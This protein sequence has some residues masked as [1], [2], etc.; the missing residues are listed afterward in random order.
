[1]MCAY[2]PGKGR[3]S[4]AGPPGLGAGRSR[5]ASTRCPRRREGRRAG[6]AAR[7]PLTTVIQL[8]TSGSGRLLRAS[9]IARAGTVAARSEPRLFS[10]AVPSA[11]HSERNAT[12]PPRSSTDTHGPLTCG[13]LI[14]EVFETDLGRVGDRGVKAGRWPRRRR[15]PRASCSSV[16]CVSRQRGSDQERGLHRLARVSRGCYA[17]FSSPCRS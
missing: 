8:P 5:T 6:A 1:V 9:S 17:Q 16:R 3:V 12:G 2:A 11:C 10:P 14:C 7:L 15:P 13:R 4:A